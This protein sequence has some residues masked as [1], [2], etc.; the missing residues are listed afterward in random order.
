MNITY[1][2]RL[3]KLDTSGISEA[4]DRELRVIAGDNKSRYSTVLAYILYRASK[5][6]IKDL[7]SI[8]LF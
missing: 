6:N 8:E 1:L 4:I 3:E 7:D 5:D 2:K